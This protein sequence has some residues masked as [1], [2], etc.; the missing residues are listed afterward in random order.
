MDLEYNTH[1]AELTA[2]EYLA[3]YATIWR[4][5]TDLELVQKAIKQTINITARKKNLL[6]GCA[7]LLSDGYLFTTITEII[8]DPRYV[9]L[10]IGRKLLELAEEASPS[11]VC[12]GSQT[13]SDELTK[14]LGWTKGPVMIFKRKDKG[15]TGKVGNRD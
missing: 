6:V 12:F 10:A 11:S 3:L 13:V 5:P 4:A 8:V 1:D 14:E 2:E 7:R 9:N 15:F